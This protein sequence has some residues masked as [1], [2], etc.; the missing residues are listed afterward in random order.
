PFIASWPGKIEAGTVSDALVSTIDI[1]PTLMDVSGGQVPERVTGK[2]LT[3]LFED[4]QADFRK[5]LFTEYN[6]DPVLYY[7]SRAVR[8]ERYK[9][10]HH[11][12]EGRKNP[13]AIFYMENSTPAFEGSP[14]FEEIRTA[15][16]S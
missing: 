12:L 1:V 4:P 7:P 16:D 11:L 13:T 9:L 5:H 2:S 8:D 6:C 15:P 14:T 10:I 3:A